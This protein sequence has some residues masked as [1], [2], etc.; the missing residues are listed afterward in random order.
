MGMILWSVCHIFLHS[1][2]EPFLCCRCLRNAGSRQSFCCSRHPSLTDTLAYLWRLCGVD[3]SHLEKPVFLYYSGQISPNVCTLKGQDAPWKLNTVRL[4]P[5][6]F[7]VAEANL[8]LSSLS[9][10]SFTKM[11]LVGSCWRLSTLSIFVGF[12]PWGCRLVEYGL[13][14]SLRHTLHWS[15]LH[16]VYSS[17]WWWQSSPMHTCMHACMCRHSYAVRLPLRIVIQLKLYF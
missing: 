12:F 7:N 16:L 1:I 6:N 8:R 5:H 9:S 3:V 2:V 10:T 14:N 11:C 15:P 17:F 13:S 4:W